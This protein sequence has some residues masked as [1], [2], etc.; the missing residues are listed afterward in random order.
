MPELLHPQPLPLP[1]QGHYRLP[2][3]LQE[4]NVVVPSDGGPVHIGLHLE[5]GYVLEIPL[6]QDAIHALL[7]T[8]QA[9]AT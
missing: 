3:A 6:T 9:L 7:G 8:L 4:A 2:A 5:G 1:P